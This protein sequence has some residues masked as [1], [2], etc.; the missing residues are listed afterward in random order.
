M[1]IRKEDLERAI[2]EIMLKI[3]ATEEEA[4]IMAEEL[5]VCDMMKCNSHGSLRV[6]QY[7]WEI[8]GGATVTGAKIQIIK[9]SPVTAVVDG[10]FG[11]G[12]VAARKMTEIVCE[13]AEKMGVAVVTGVNVRHIGR[14]GSFVQ[15]MAK[16][17]LIGFAAV[18]VCQSRP[19]IPW[20]AAE[21]R[22]STNP[23]AWS[24]PRYGEECVFFDAAMTTVSEGKLRNYILEGEPVPEGWLKDADGNP[25]TDPNTF[26]Q[27]PRSTINPLGGDVRGMK[28]SGL[29]L[30]TALFSNALNNEDYWSGNIR[31]KEKR[32]HNGVFFMAVNP[33]FFCGKEEYAKQVKNHC[34][35]IKSAKPLEGV[36]EVLVPGEY[37]L[38]A[39]EESLKIGIHLPDNTWE[40]LV[41][42]GQKY[43][44]DFAAGT[45]S[46]S[47]KNPFNY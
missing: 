3:G 18:S 46:V 9:E 34:D 43:Q 6:P 4:G 5:T 19:M 36:E 22:L 47:E 28:G 20:G 2:Y 15:E 35:Y 30:M 40:S 33:D 45:E 38:K 32:R 1:V 31:G 23:I 42:L 24:A 26:Y 7:V 44:C 10:G 29:A 25:T 21:P 27:E 14:V 41:F 8:E 12:Q 11:F 17:G 39:Y 37:E 16:R 13:K